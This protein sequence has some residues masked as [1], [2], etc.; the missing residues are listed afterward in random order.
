MQRLVG[1]VVLVLALGIAPAFALAQEV[2][3]PRKLDSMS[4]RDREREMQAE[5]WQGPSG[6]WTS[7]HKATH[8]AYRYRLM[9]I[10]GA[11]LLGMGFFTYRLLKKASTDRAA[12]GS[13]SKV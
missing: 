10:G 9:G 4:L 3:Q 1:F 5:Q 11:L 6:F 2:E 12:R 8:G 7:P 13:P